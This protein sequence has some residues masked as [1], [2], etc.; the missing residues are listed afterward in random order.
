[1]MMVF[2]NS[3]LRSIFGPKRGEVTWEWKKLHNE[4][5]NDL[6]Y[7][8]NIFRVINARRMIW[9]EHT[10]CMG[11]RRDVYR[12]LLGKPG[13]KQFGRLR[14]RWEDNIKMDLYEV[15]CEIMEWIYLS[16]DRDRCWAHVNAVMKLGV[17]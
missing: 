13:K 7:S 4:E 6:Y 15:G 16:Q 11:E 17:L 2:K 3:V 14:R 8:P 12:V 5:L 1:M 10:A 9:A